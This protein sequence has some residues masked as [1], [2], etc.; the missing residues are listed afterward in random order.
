MG[1]SATGLTSAAG[2]G[3]VADT[4]AAKLRRANKEALALR[5]TK[6]MVRS[7]GAS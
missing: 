3:S 7:G 4:P 1:D 6:G 5:D 2:F